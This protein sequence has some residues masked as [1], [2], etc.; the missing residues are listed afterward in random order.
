M[1]FVNYKK[2]NLYSAALKKGYTYFENMTFLKLSNISV[3]I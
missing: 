2:K 1:H 3:V